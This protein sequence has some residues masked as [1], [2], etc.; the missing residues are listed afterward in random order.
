[1]MKLFFSLSIILS[2]YG[3]RLSAD[4][5]INP[6]TD[7]CWECLFPITLS[8]MNVT[9]SEKDFTNYHTRVCICPGMPPRIGV[10]LTFWEPTRLVDVTRHAY[11]LIGLGGLSIGSEN[12]KNRGS[13][14]ISSTGTQNSFYQVHWY[15]YPIFSLLEIFTDF[16]C[17]EKGD[18]D[19]AYMSEFDP[20]W[21][22]DS[23]L[24]ILEPEAGLFANPLAQAACIA[25]CIEASSSYAND[26]LF[27]CAG[28]EGSLYPL[29]G[30]VAH[31][32][33]GTQASALLVHRIIAKLHRLSLIKGFEKDNFCEAKP[34]PIIKKSLY[35]TQLVRPVPQTSG[36]CQPL[37][38]SDMIW[39]TGKSYPYGGE[40]FVYLIWTKKHCCLDALKAAPVGALP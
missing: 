31:H 22:D 36:A 9:P 24:A 16:L 2:L 33:G 5:I 23:L 34:M 6:I 38:K 12:I 7:I 17:V 18:L 4:N 11:K 14:G 3:T 29:G 15:V 25:D 28:C 20:T 40:D 35:K 21:N 32:V 37:G 13:V 27:W 10:P 8:G 1:M 39:G 19:L 26:H 30:S